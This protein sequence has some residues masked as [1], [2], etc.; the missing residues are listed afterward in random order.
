MPKPDTRGNRKTG[1]T[2]TRRMT[3]S[4][5][6]WMDDAIARVADESEGLTQADVARACLEHGLAAL[7]GIE[8][9]TE[10]P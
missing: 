7:Y 6:E 5:E 9:P 8:R 2:Y 4:L 3:Y 1:L 10:A